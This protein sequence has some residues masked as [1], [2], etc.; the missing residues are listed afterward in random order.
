MFG[1]RNFGQC[2]TA[3]LVMFSV[4][5]LAQAPP[6]VGSKA[7]LWPNE[8]ALSPSVTPSSPAVRQVGVAYALWHYDTK[9]KSSWGM[10]ELGFYAS[11]DPVAMQ[12]HAV[13]LAQAGVDFILVDWS[14]N[15][16]ADHRIHKG[17]PQQ[18]IVEDATHTLFD[19]FSHYATAPKISLMIGNPLEP[20][21]VTN[22][23]LQHKADQVWDEYAGNEQYGKMM[24][25]YLGKALLVVYVNTP[26]PYQKGIPA[27]TDPRFSVRYMTGF[28]SDQPA[29]HDANNVSKYGYW[30]WED[31]GVQSYPIYQNH[32]EFMSVVPAWRGN[33][34]HPSPG[35]QNGSTY[36]QEWARARAIGPN[37]VLAGTFNEW[38]RGEQPSADESKDLEPSVELGHRYLRILHDQILLFKAGK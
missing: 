26:S 21:A 28:V 37:I 11:S 5:C 3:G 34:A 15:L 1:R 22:G 12:A 17:T 9:W 7:D 27:W 36:V 18:N 13:W 8:P 16:N 23:D 4:G 38:K 2:V 24:E 6:T 14:N 31:R 20:A 19:V 32:P 30:S 25:M 29:L 35:R 10:P 33:A